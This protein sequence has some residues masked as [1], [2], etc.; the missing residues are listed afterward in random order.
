MSNH[1]TA[2]SKRFWVK[3]FLTPVLFF[4]FAFAMV[5][6]YKVFCEVTGLN[7]KTSNDVYTGEVRTV[8]TSRT[9]SV[10]TVR[11]PDTKFLLSYSVCGDNS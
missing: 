6:L 10:D 9:V 1:S 2:I 4:A 7:G 8:D 5:P 11:N 3:L